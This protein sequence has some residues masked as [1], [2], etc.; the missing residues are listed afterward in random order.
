MEL[1]GE[2]G[3]LL[4][5]RLDDPLYDVPAHPLGEIDGGCGPVRE[6]LCEPDVLFDESWVAPDLVMGDDD[7][8]RPAVDDERHV[9]G[10][11]SAEPARELVVD[12]GV[13]DD[14]V[15]SLAATSFEHPP[16]L[17]GAS[18]PRWPAAPT[19]GR[20]QARPRASRSPVTIST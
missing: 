18:F 19:S 11:A 5:L 1:S 2:P 9:E 6:H 4:L 7:A 3:T 16:C 20:T 8:D 12:L 14:H 13:V 17:R 10:G 15:D